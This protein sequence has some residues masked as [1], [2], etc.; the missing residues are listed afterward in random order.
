[1]LGI[2]FLA[3]LG[4]YCWLRAY[5]IAD[6]SV[7][8]PVGYLSIVMVTFTG[9]VFFDEVPEMRVVI[10]VLVILA[11]LQGAAWLERRRSVM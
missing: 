6:A 9:Y 3:Q 11:A 8:A 7:L 1:M 10:G 5:R 4:Q 2:G